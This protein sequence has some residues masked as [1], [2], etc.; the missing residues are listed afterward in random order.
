MTGVASVAALRL[1]DEPPL[2][3]VQV[4]RHS[5]LADY[6]INIFKNKDNIIFCIVSLTL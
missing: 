1:N 2:V 4:E 5:V 6:E 3:I